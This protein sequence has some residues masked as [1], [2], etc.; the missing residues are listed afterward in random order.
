MPIGFVDPYVRVGFGYAWLG[1]FQLNSMYA[2]S[3]SNIDGW[4]GKIGV[5]LD[6][7][8]APFLTI[9]AGVDA[10]VINLRR[11][12]VMRSGSECPSTDPTCVELTMDG[13]S[14]GTLVVFHLQAALHI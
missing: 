5:G 4:T 10:S 2:M 3:T 1:E 7:W 14:I 6:L 9:G 13:D 11:G 8:L 12:G